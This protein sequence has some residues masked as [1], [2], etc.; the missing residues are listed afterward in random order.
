MSFLSASR[1]RMHLSQGLKFGF[2]GALATAVDFAVFNLL[3]AAA[4]LDPRFASVFSAPFGLVTVFLLNKYVSF[5]G[6]EGAMQVQIVRFLLVYGVSYVLHVTLI[7]LFIT[8]AVRALGVPSTPLLA[9]AAKALTVG[10]IAL[11]NYA[12][13]HSFVFR[14]RRP[15]WK[16]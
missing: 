1:V 14:P 2:A 9:N 11:W 8:L 4:G 7:A 6:R 12:L 16:P 13:L 10:C 3:L 15:S 5:R